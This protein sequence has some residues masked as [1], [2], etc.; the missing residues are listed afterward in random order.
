MMNTPAWIGD[1]LDQSMAKYAWVAE[2]HA[3]ALPYTTDSRGCYDNRADATRP[4]AEAD[5]INWWTNGMWPGIMWHLYRHTGEQRYADIARYGE[6]LLDRCFD[7]FMGLH[8]DVGFMWLPSAVADYTL[9]GR[10]RSRVRA[11]H[12]ATILAGRFNPE[13]RFFRAWNDMGEEGVQPAGVAIIDCM[14]NLPLLY[15][16][17]TETGDPRF[18]QMARAHARTVADS[19]MRPD[20]SVSHIVQFD[21]LSGRKLRVLPGQGFCADGAWTRGQAWA[22]YGFTVGYAMTGQRWQLDAALRTA[23]FWLAHMPQSGVIPVDFAQPPELAL[24]D[25]CA[26][27]IASCALLELARLMEGA[28][29]E[30]LQQAAFTMLKALHEGRCCYDETC[31]AIVGNCTGAYHLT[32]TRHIH[33]VYADYFYLEA[34]CKVRGRRDF[35]W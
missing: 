9:T 31:D 6:T 8:H 30:R 35:I 25:S 13:G 3:C 33:M 15:W 32:G 11:L 10:A 16:A 24:E 29:A 21:P 4:W 26:A 7:D 12:A 27:A 17:S 14:M 18:G 22:M 19:F 34:L 23:E 5:G 28:E 1:A 20:G 2:K